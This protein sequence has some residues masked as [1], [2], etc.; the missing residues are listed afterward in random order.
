M[1]AFNIVSIPRIKNAAADLL[2]TSAAR[3]VPTNNRCS[4]ELIFRPVVP[5]NI[6]NLRVF[7]DDPQ[8]LEFLTNDEN[9]KGAVIDDE[10]H[11]ANLRSGNFIPKGVIN[12]EGMF[13]LNNK[14]R[15]PAK[16]K[17]H[18]SSMQFELV[19]LG[20]EAKPKYVNMRK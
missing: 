13:D 17:T 14:F 3:L 9:F 16:V 4:I 20:L 2:S 19:N 5:D 15:R 12:L 10:E 1:D 18:S 8:I 6:T 11:Q 7:D